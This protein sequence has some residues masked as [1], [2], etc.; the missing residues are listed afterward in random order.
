[1]DKP[2]QSDA[3]F[4]QT[5]DIPSYVLDDLCSRF[6]INLPDEEQQDFIRIF[7]AIEQAHWFYLD[8][9]CSERP[10]LKNCGI[11]E[12]SLQILRHIPAL[13]IYAAEHEKY[14]EE[15][16]AYKMAVPTYGAILLTPDFKHCLL[17]QGFFTKSSWGF[18]KGKVNEAESPVECAIREVF[19][20]T[21]LDV[22]SLIKADQYVETRMNDQLIRLF[23]IPGVAHDTRFQPQTRKEIR[24]LKWFPVDA[25]P[26]HKRDTTAKIQ[27]NMGANSFFMVIPF[28]KGLRR[29][30]SKASGQHHPDKA[31]SDSKSRGTKGEEGHDGKQ[32]R[33]Q[34][35]PG[36]QGDA[37]T[38]RELPSGKQNQT[39]RS[40]PEKLKKPEQSQQKQFQ[41][42]VRGA[43]VKK[44]Q[45]EDSKTGTIQP[46]DQ[47]LNTSCLGTLFVQSSFACDEW[48]FSHYFCSVIFKL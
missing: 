35:R 5:T 46:S 4:A 43:S 30:I 48:T 6:I 47:N 36:P 25:L 40:A 12:F 7:F 18:P 11:K 1:M 8:F 22:K 14:L 13:K 34:N 32:K 39:A 45:E 31:G 20:E 9:Y 44:S 33:Q 23:I 37:P 42:L 10:E 16:R 28:I 3:S 26:I 15:W 2:Q 17:A 24:E 19:E 27:L 29:W 21:G 41:I 38:A